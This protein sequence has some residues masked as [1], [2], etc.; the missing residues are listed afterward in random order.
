MA[1]T[2]VVVLRGE[3]QIQSAGE[4]VLDACPFEVEG[5]LSTGQKVKVLIDFDP[6]DRGY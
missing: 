3:E 4:N 6:D 1:E 5:T 2:V